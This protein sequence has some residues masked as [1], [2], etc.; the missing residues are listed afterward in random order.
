M[1]GSTNSLDSLSSPSPSPPPSLSR[2]EGSVLVSA[3]TKPKSAEP[4][5][6]L[7]SDSELSELTEEEQDE[8]QKHK[9]KQKKS[10]VSSL[11]PGAARSSSSNRRG[12]ASTMR[13]GPR[14][15]GRKKRS[16]LV[17]APMW[18]WAMYGSEQ[19][20]ENHN[21]GG[22]E[23]EG[24]D[25]KEAVHI[26]HNH[27]SAPNPLD[28]LTSAALSA[29]NPEQAFARLKS[30]SQETEEEEEKL[31]DVSEVKG[32]TVPADGDIDM[33]DLVTINRSTV[34][35]NGI[36]SPRASTPDSIASSR[37]SPPNNVPQVAYASTSRI[38]T[39]ASTTE[40]EDDNTDIEENEI[41]P[42]EQ[43][44]SILTAKSRSKPNL[45]ID[46][47]AQLPSHI[48]F[49]SVDTPPSSFPPNTTVSDKSP[50]TPSTTTATATN[51][52]AKASRGGRGRGRGRGRARTRGMRV[53]VPLEADRPPALGIDEVGTS[54]SYRDS[55]P[56]RETLMDHVS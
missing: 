16:T 34:V 53:A 25:G 14:R 43:H 33:A 21:V 29:E 45:R 17:P 46:A 36:A 54:G 7:D 2:A 12:T 39:G 51:S 5:A 28:V 38:P 50:I 32:V 47:S 52:K 37:P 31:I 8:K 27:I 26:P 20:T 22:E 13:G 24:N 55:S 56:A 40:D 44:K 35:A 4:A 10:E 30:D 6:G 41:E 1:G 15:G 3:S 18:G 9:Q 23:I 49:N 11:S 48:P 19:D 42:D